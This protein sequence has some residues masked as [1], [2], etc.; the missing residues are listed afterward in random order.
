MR[1]WIV[2]EIVLASTAIVFYGT[3]SLSFGLIEK[4]MVFE[5]IIRESLVLRH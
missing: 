2:Q 5:E 1:C 4:V 3:T